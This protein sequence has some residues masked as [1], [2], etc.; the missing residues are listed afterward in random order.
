M[1]ISSYMG[2]STL[3]VPDFVSLRKN[4][5]IQKFQV[6]DAYFYLVIALSEKTSLQISHSLLSKTVDFEKNTHSDTIFRPPCPFL[7]TIRLLHNTSFGTHVGL[8]KA[9]CKK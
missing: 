7:Q 9:V 3:A 5:D 4:S 2:G 6:N 1:S 8:L